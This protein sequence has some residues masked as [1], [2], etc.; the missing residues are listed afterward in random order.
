MSILRNWT[1]ENGWHGVDPLVVVVECGGEDV[2]SF[3]V[4]HDIASMVV[5][6]TKGNPNIG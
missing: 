5:G 1:L 3:V 2:E 4:L 6:F